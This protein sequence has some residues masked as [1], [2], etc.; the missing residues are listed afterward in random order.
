MEERLQK[1][2]ARGGLASRRAAEKLITEGKV[3]VNGR[4]V[5]EL[6][7]KADPRNDKIEVDGARVVAERLV[8]VAL[9]KPRGYV[10]TMSDPEGRPCVK[11]LLGGVG[12]RVFPIGRLDFATS[13]LLLATNDGAFSDGLLHPKREVPKT[14]IV[15][16]HGLMQPEDLERWRTGVNLEDGVTAPAE[17][18]L[19]RHEAGKTWMELTIHEGRNQQIRRMGDATGFSV[20]RLSRV[21]FAGITLEGLKPGAWRFLT[22]D[23]LMALKKA[24]GVPRAIVSPPMPDAKRKAPTSRAGAE[25]GRGE[26]GRDERGRGAE[27]GHGAERGRGAG[28]GAERGRGASAGAE[29]GRVAA[30]SDGR[31]RGP[32]RKGPPRDRN[33]KGGRPGGS[34]RS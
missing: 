30:P 29:R 16:T 32:A 3:R 8:Y 6:G 2:L 25:R 22:R 11:E 20:M 12:V 17:A 5:R 23:E 31:G 19:I 1:I 34:R 10:S 13:G 18:T 26:R 7:A 21:V 33:A 28:A 27:R 9:H 15:K 14:Y 4:V 24:Y